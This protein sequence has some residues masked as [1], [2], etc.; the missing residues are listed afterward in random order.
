MLRE[1]SASRV[2]SLPALLVKRE[3]DYAKLLRLADRGGLVNRLGFVSDVA[4][5]LAKE[6]HDWKNAHRLQKLLVKLWTRRNAE[7]EE[8]L[9]REPAQAPNLQSWLKKQTLP[10]GKKWG[11]YGINTLRDF[12]EALKRTA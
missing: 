9:K 11:V 3:T 2:E 5:L 7:S 10:A 8:F 1:P 12:R 4:L 6:N